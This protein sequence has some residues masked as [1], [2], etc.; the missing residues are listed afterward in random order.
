[1]SA[2]QLL[3]SSGVFLYEV[4]PFLVEE[5][6]PKKPVN[7]DG[8]EEEYSDKEP[9][10][11]ETEESIAE[12]SWQRLS[13]LVSLRLVCKDW[14]DG[15]VN[16]SDFWNQFMI[17]NLENSM[18]ARG[19]DEKI[20]IEFPNKDDKNSFMLNCIRNS[21][22]ARNTIDHLTEWDQYKYEQTYVYN[23][24]ILNE[25]NDELISEMI[26]LVSPFI[27]IEKLDISTYSYDQSDVEINFTIANI[28]GTTQL[29]KLFFTV[30]RCDYGNGNGD[31]LRSNKITMDEGTVTLVETEILSQNQETD[32]GSWIKRFTNSDKN[33]IKEVM[34]KI[35]LRDLNAIEMDESYR[36]QAIIQGIERGKSKAVDYNNLTTTLDNPLNMDIYRDESTCTEMIQSRLNRFNISFDDYERYYKPSGSS[37][38]MFL[39]QSLI[40]SLEMY[41]FMSSEVSSEY[42]THEN[43][44]LPEKYMEYWPNKSYMSQVKILVGKKLMERKIG[45]RIESSSGWYQFVKNNTNNQ[46]FSKKESNDASV[47]ITC[48]HDGLTLSEPSMGND[49][50]VIHSYSNPKYRGS[51]IKIHDININ[52]NGGGY[53]LSPDD[54]VIDTKNYYFEKF[55]EDNY[56]LTSIRYGLRVCI[57]NQ[58]QLSGL[59]VRLELVDDRTNVEVTCVKRERAGKRVLKGKTKE[60]FDLSKHGNLKAKLDFRFR[61][62]SSD[63]V[64]EWF[65]LNVHILMDNQKLLTFSSEPFRTSVRSPTKKSTRQA[66]APP[67]N[68]TIV[69]M[70]LVGNSTTSSSR[71]SLDDEDDEDQYDNDEEDDNDQQVD[72]TNA[73]SSPP[74]QQKKVK[75][76]ISQTSA[77]AY[78]TPPPPQQGFPFYPSYAQQVPPRQ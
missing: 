1:M 39:T 46:E 20:E 60:E 4:I 42:Q 27:F 68:P 17:K 58:T 69:Q 56:L 63:N 44:L 35:G 76:V 9:I 6:T 23:P 77:S 15:F 32:E 74:P 75:G 5:K 73:S 18:K 41:K 19:N 33:I 72:E 62:T 8:A 66:L 21:F 61:E 7:L 71:R 53:L 12:T 34:E 78:Q 30:Y 10:E 54:V 29:T 52:P 22:L 36:I 14:N 25:F 47:S 67:L 48:F 59:F 49:I 43:D 26:R 28:Q 37:F 65:R 45:I 57:P 2:I 55:Y 50:P 24:A 13:Y 16:A 38:D 3:L 70:G 11:E 64:V 51:S 40:L 31:L